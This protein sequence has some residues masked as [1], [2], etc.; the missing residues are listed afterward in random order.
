MASL[1]DR[2]EQPRI[3]TVNI[4]TALFFMASARLGSLNAMEQRFKEMGRRSRWR[5]RLGAWLPSADRM[6]EVAALLEVDELRAG[7]YE[8][9][10]LRKRAKTLPPL[11]PGG[12]R[13][14]VLDGH[15]LGASYLRNCSRCLER[16]CTVA[17]EKHTQYYHRYVGAYLLT[18]GERLMLDAELLEPGEG[19]IAAATRLLERLL[20]HLPRAFDVVAGDALYLHPDLCRRVLEANK[21]FV[22]VLKNEN[23]DLIQDFRGLTAQFEPRCLRY[24]ARSCLC[25]DIEGFESWTQLGHPVRVVSSQ[26]RWNVR[27]QRAKQTQPQTTQWLWATSLPKTKASTAAVVNIGHRRWD[28]E[29]QG[30]NELDNH[31]SAGHI[32]HHDPAAILAILLIIFL[33]YNLVHVWLARGLKPQLRRRHTAKHLV[34]RIKAAFYHEPEAPP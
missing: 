24:G 2:R 7:L 4:V 29:N 30:F 11:M 27:R 6:G 1:R 20:T 34:Q 12:V 21:D 14:L 33:A 10:R 3:P 22:A 16:E 9:H 23:R 5:G 18:G 19:E 31:W 25:H 17:G 32:Y 13:V 8:H 26:E 28:I 15:E